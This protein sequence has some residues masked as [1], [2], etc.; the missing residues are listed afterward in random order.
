M[1]KYSKLTD[2]RSNQ[3]ESHST[4][5]KEGVTPIY[6]ASD[7]LSKLISLSNKHSLTKLPQALKEHPIAALNRISRTHPKRCSP[8]AM[9]ELWQQLETIDQAI[10]SDNFQVWTTSRNRVHMVAPWPA[11]ILLEALRSLPKAW[12]QCIKLR[13]KWWCPINQMFQWTE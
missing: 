2:T 7:H 1:N 12:E 13:H 5:K 10:M 4:T 6:L 8:K 3:Q 9:R 11:K